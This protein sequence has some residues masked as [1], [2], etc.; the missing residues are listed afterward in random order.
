MFLR[1]IGVI[2]LSSI[3][4]GLISH[5]VSKI[6]SYY[7]FINL[8]VSLFSGIGA[9]ASDDSLGLLIAG[10]FG[11]VSGFFIAI[12]I[13]GVFA[14]EIFSKPNNTKLFLI[15]LGVG[16]VHSLIWFSLTISNLPTY[17]ERIIEK[18]SIWTETT[19]IETIVMS[20]IGFL[21]SLVSGLLVKFL[22]LNQSFDATKANN[23]AD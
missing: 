2:V 13:A 19:F 4:G 16:I 5:S 23:Y 11:V 1:Y 18:P 17:D 8:K 20:V 14:I 3:C 7:N 22:I 21:I 9:T 10:L 12:V 6:A 15:T